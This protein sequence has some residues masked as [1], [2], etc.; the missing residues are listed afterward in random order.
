MSPPVLQMQVHLPGMHMVAYKPNDDLND[1]V[2]RDKSQRSMLTEYFRLNQDNPETHKYLY[3]EIP[4]HFR[5][6]KANTQWVPRK[7]RAQIGRLVYAHPAEGERYYLRV[8]LNHVRGACSFENLRSFSGVTYPTFRA[9][10]EAMG[11]VEAD[12]TLDDCLAEATSFN[13]PC[14]VRRLFAIIM[15]FCECAHLRA[16]WEKHFDSMAADYW[17][18]IDSHSLLEQRVLG[19]IS[20]HCT[21][22]DKDINSYGLPKLLESADNTRDHYRD[23]TKELKVGYEE[24]HLKLVDTLNSEQRVGFDEILDHV[25]SERPQVFFVDGPGGTGKTHLYRAL[26]A[27]VRSM[28]RI[29]IATAT[30]GIAAS[31]M[32]GGRTAHSRFKIPIKLGGNTMCSFTKQ[33]GIAELFRR[34]A[35]IIWD[36]V[37]MTKRQAVETLDRTLQDI[38]GSSH[39]FGGKVMVFGGDFRQVLPVVAH[40]TRAQITDACLS[41]SYIWNSVW[42][43][44]LS[45]NMR[46]QSDTRFAEYLLRI[47]NGTEETFGDDYV[48]LPDNILVEWNDGDKCSKEKASSDN[49]PIDSLIEHVFPKLCENCTCSAYMFPGKEKV[50]YSFDSVDDDSR[51]NYP[52]DFLNSITPN[53]LPP[54][55]LKLKKNCPIILLHNIDPH[56]GLCNGTRMVVRRLENN[57]IDAEIVNGQHAD[58]QMN[59]DRIAA[60]LLRLAEPADQ[61]KP[62]RGRGRGPYPPRCLR[63]NPP[64]PRPPSRGI[65]EARRPEW[66]VL[67]ANEGSRRRRYTAEG[68]MKSVQDHVLRLQRKLLGSTGWETRATSSD[69]EEQGNCC[70][71][72]RL[73]FGQKECPESLRSKFHPDASI[74]PTR[75]RSLASPS[76][77]KAATMPRP[78]RGSQPHGREKDVERRK[79]GGRGPARALRRREPETEDQLRGGR[80]RAAE[81]DGPGTPIIHHRCQTAKAK[82]VCRSMSRVS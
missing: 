36:E 16:L 25:L 62:S 22:M 68:Y 72:L 4:E 3:G 39:P 75:L 10:C 82:R 81:Q 35:L 1:V 44:Q 55:Q 56:N 19:D 58:K 24:E 31:I 76:K 54:H 38:M 21:S 37:A 59:G 70:L 52:L 49:H 32:R 80:R 66:N 78:L 27:K 47:G 34:A 9:A 45:Q 50:Y 40:G 13:M 7:Q 74:L 48:Q 11:F 57:T 33:S 79:R 30:S 61:L 17:K 6:I 8:L 43:I 69:A 28:D 12:A 73:C 2:Q 77:S 15:V 65:I 26:L 42:R 51:N 60:N 20:Y 46:A 23:L 71:R 67:A 41:K 53:G 29:A 14:A 18:A 63:G 5:W 64:P